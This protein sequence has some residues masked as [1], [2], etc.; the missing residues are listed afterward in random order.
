MTCQSNR[1]IDTSTNNFAI[2]KNGDVSVQRFSPFSPSAAY[3]LSTIGGSAYFDGTGDYL[4][5][6][7]N[8]AFNFGSGNF[9][10]ECWFNSSVTSTAAVIL[11]QHGTGINQ[12]PWIVY[13]NGSNIQFYATSNGSTW[14]IASALAVGTITNNAWYHVA[15]T[16]S[17]S[18]F[19]TFL[20]GVAGATTTSSATLFSN[21]VS[22][23]VG[24]NIEALGDYFTGYISNA[25]LIKGT[26]V[27]TA[28]FTP[29]TAPVTAITNTSLLLNFTNAGIIDNAMLNDLETVGNAQI[30]TAQSK[31][32][33]GA[34]FFDGTGD[35][36]FIKQDNPALRFGTAPF[37][38]ECWVYLT[39]TVSSQHFF[40]KG[41]LNAGGVFF[42]RSAGNAGKLAWY[43]S[44]TEIIT[45]SSALSLN[46]W[47]HIAYVRTST[48]ASGAKIY[49]NGVS[50]GTGTDS[51]NY[52]NTDSI[53][54]GAEYAGTN[55]MT[56]YID[57]YRIT[58]GVARYTANFTPPTA[59]L[60]TS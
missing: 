27:Y 43:V 48:S 29:P 28:A 55:P 49:I 21:S 52:T 1:L 45:T 4:S 23:A 5:I 11:A 30:S 7:N 54:I 20:N 42:T 12:G 60:P 24:A 2:T 9:T 16:R 46:Q 13:R 25:R 32:G 40:F 50:S 34:M 22:V 6:A 51:T 3:S 17:G 18:T 36:L 44:E 10:I 58:T 14:N 26:A 41:S 59:A 8:A 35:Y 19:Y 53:A 47:T 56:G 15:V 38:I 39:S 57:D 37:T 33:A 31:F